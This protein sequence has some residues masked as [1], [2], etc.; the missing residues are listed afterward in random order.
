MRLIALSAHHRTCRP[1]AT[2]LGAGLLLLTALAAP[3]AA[4]A[5]G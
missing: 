3:R 4:W 1:L 5:Q 2:G